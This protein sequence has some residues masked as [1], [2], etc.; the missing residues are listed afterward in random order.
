[1]IIIDYAKL[2]FKIFIG[3]ENKFYYIW[4]NILKIE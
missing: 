1:M 4:I 3:F 2:S